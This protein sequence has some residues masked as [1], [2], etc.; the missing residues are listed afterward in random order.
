MRRGAF[1]LTELLVSVVILS[2]LAAAMVQ[3]YWMLEAKKSAFEKR[4]ERMERRAKTA[5]LLYEDLLRAEEI[6]FEP[7]ERVG[8]VAIKGGRSIFGIERPW[9]LWYVS[10][11]DG[12]LCRLESAAR[13]SLPLDPERIHYANL[14]PL[15]KGCEGFVITRSA[16]GRKLFVSLSF[17]GAKPIYFALSRPEKPKRKSSS[18]KPAAKTPAP[19]APETNGSR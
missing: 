11:K 15:L 17:A 10:R 4:E 7:H 6:R 2:F 13:V 8:A 5:R 12:T 9:V 14:T 16:D 18:A 3:I 19:A 1:T